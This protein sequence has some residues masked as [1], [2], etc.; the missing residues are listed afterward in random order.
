MS[1]LMPL[2]WL[3]PIAL[4][5]GVGGYRISTLLSSDEDK[6]ERRLHWLLGGFEERSPRRI[7][8][9]F[10]SFYK[11]EDTGYGKDQVEQAVRTVAVPGTRYRAALDPDDGILYVEPPRM[12]GSYKHATVDLH[13]LIEAR[14]G[15][16]DEYRPY[17]EVRGRVV[18]QHRDSRWFIIASSGVNWDTMPN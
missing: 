17:W 5:V 3:V 7:A 13:F 2:R 16:T 18:L 15:A 1:K 9:G 14:H 12:H 6:I 11:D 4:L 8:R 10:M